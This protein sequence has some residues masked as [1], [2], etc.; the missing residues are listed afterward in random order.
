MKIS[1]VYSMH[2]Y[3]DSQAGADPKQMS[4]AGRT[5]LHEASQGGHSKVLQLLLEH[6]DCI[7][8]PDKDGQTPAHIA[9]FNGELECLKLLLD[10]GET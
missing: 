4:F 10:K 3:T 1:N 8:I 9:A 6:V 5:A 2:I 7:D